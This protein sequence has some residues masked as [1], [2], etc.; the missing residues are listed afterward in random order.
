MFIKDFERIIMSISTAHAKLPQIVEELLIDVIDKNPIHQR[1]LTSSVD[2]ISP[3]ELEELSI[4]IG[5]CIEKGLSVAYLADCYLTIVEDTFREQIYFMTNKHYRY[6]KFSDVAD[7]VYHNT[8]YMD[9]Y[10]YGLAISSFLWP[11]HIKM[12]REFE[13]TLPKEQAGRYLEIGPG[14]GHHIM[15]AMKLSA[16]DEFI[17]VDISSASIKQTQSIV[18]H[19]HEDVDSRFKLKQMDFLDGTEFAADEFDA[20]V[21][22]EVLEHVER[23][24]LFLR[25]IREIV[26]PDGYVFITT[27]INAPA[28]DHIYLWRSTD[29]LEKLITDCGLSITSA[30]RLPYE[31]KTIEE[32]TEQAL[33]INVAYVLR[34]S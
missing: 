26:K 31:G 33:A 6:N 29:E 18:E 28:I 3:S 5:Y 10:M 4:Y 1:F 24:E 14:H 17:G 2:I 15:S 11:N 9:R 21:M 34:A 13:Q 25:R 30:L 32:S 7:H 20:V 19:F 22:G 8:E 12:A 23:P 27:C 16:Y